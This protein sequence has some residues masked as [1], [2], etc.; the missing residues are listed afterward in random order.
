MLEDVRQI[1]QDFLA[2]ELRAIAASLDA[3]D[4]R[5][6]GTDSCFVAAEKIA[7]AR[8]R[9]IMTRFEMVHDQIG[10]VNQKIAIPRCGA[11][12]V[13]PLPSAYLRYLPSA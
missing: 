7:E 11:G 1:F 9:E 10:N 13:D 12:E 8:H 4:K 5:F 6:E 2:P 3:I